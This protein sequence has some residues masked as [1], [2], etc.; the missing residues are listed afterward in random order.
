VQRN[1]PGQDRSGIDG[2]PPR[3]GRFCS[4]LVQETGTEPLDPLPRGSRLDADHP[5]NGV[6]IACRFTPTG[7]RAAW[8]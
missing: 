7:L 6:L 2:P 8:S 4:P 5:E 1:R 3:T